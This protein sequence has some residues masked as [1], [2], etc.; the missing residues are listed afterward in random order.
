[1]AFAS[2][3]IYQYI[4]SKTDVNIYVTGHLFYQIV[5]TIHSPAI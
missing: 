3:Y 1:M 4:P 5:E 2:I